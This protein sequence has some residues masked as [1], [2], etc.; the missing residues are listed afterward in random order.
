MGQVD[1]GP[2]RFE[3]RGVTVSSNNTGKLDIIHCSCSGQLS[4]LHSKRFYYSLGQSVMSCLVRSLH[5]STRGWMRPLCTVCHAWIGQVP[6]WPTGQVLRTCRLD[7][8]VC[9]LI[10]QRLNVR[11]VSWQATLGQMSTMQTWLVRQGLLSISQ[12]LVAQVEVWRK[13]GPP[14]GLACSAWPTLFLLCLFVS[15]ALPCCLAPL[16]LQLLA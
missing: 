1:R 7:V 11:G 15:L 9:L 4:S 6:L 5:G 8:R 3:I 10:N 14:L 13:V 12:Q 16:L 2:L